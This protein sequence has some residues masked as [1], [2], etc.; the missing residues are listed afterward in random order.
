MKNRKINIK[1]FAPFFISEVD[2]GS[3]FTQGMYMGGAETHAATLARGMARE[4]TVT[5]IANR[6]G[7]Q[8]RAEAYDGLNVRRYRARVILGDIAD[9]W[10][11]GMLLEILRE[12]PHIIH[13]HHYMHFSSFVGCIVGKLIGVPIVIS[14]HGLRSQGR[15][16]LRLKEWL[17]GRSNIRWASAIL[18]P[19]QAARQE[20]DKLGAAEEKL[21][22]IYHGI[23]TERFVPLDVVEEHP[24]TLLFVGRLESSK[25]LFYLIEAMK[26]LV[27]QGLNIR[28]KIVGRGSEYNTLTE[29]CR[30]YS[31]DQNVQFLG[32]VEDDELPEVYATS[33]LFV[34]P[35][36]YEKGHFTEVFGL[37]LAE[38][39]ACGLPVLSTRNGGLAEVVL[40]GKNGFFIEQRNS[41]DIAAN[42]KRLYERPDLLKEMARFCVEDAKTRFSN[43]KMIIQTEALYWELTQRPE[44]QDR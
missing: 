35:S 38:A 9:P 30:R 40:E 12:R 19:S 5:V 11:P 8:P 44:G 27:G 21:R 37:V 32:Y 42:I 34:H 18:L 23:D 17:I 25:G 24:F 2:H 1:Y 29:L 3:N 22:V 41:G 14:H 7:N 31:L 15:R 26:T 13:C 10:A 33:D 20:L 16:F 6:L 4:H 36:L 39:M 43:R 28:L